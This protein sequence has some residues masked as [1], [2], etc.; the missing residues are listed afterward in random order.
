MKHR[1]GGCLY[2]H[3]GIRAR[4]WRILTRVVAGRVVH[5][6]WKAELECSHGEGGWHWEPRGSGWL[7]GGGTWRGRG[8]RRWKD[9]LGSHSGGTWAEALG[10]SPRRLT[11]SPPQGPQSL[12]P[13]PSA[14]PSN[15]HPFSG[16]PPHTH[17]SS[18]SPRLG[19]ELCELSSVCMLPVPRFLWCSPKLLSKPLFTKAKFYF[20]QTQHVTINV[21]ILWLK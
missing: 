14:F 21:I 10:L 20:L 2:L 15:C 12:Y 3:G 6:R 4:P 11:S 1:R 19:S 9:A 7:A 5:C 17:S 8:E 18:F 13:S 16:K